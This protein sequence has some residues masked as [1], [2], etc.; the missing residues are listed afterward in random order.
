MEATKAKE[1][2]KDLPSMMDYYGPVI[3]RT[4]RYAGVSTEELMRIIG[5][6]IGTKLAWTF[7]GD[8]PEDLV[9]EFAE[10]WTELDIGRIELEKT[11]PVIFTV[12]DCLI[13]DQFPGLGEE[14]P[15][16]FHEGFFDAVLKKRLGLTA[17]I[18]QIGTSEGAG[19]TRNRTFQ[20][21]VD[22]AGSR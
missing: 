19:R 22:S 7:K 20:I 3:A 17:I 8:T 1:F 13:C 10:L 14:S 4:Q 2:W 6:V 18:K 5:G 9:S 12:H 21:T 15:C 11:N 16:A